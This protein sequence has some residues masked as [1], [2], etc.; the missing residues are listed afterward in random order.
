MGNHPEPPKHQSKPPNTA[1]RRVFCWL[2]VD[3]FSTLLLK[4]AWVCFG[5]G[6]AQNWGT[7]KRQPHLASSTVVR[8]CCFDKQFKIQSGLDSRFKNPGQ[9]FQ[10]ILNLESKPRFPSIF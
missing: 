8:F 10:G 1:D 5:F 7:V 9:A 6:A 3:F 4:V 2:G